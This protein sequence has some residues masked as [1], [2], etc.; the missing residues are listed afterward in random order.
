MKSIIL[1]SLL[2]TTTNC[3]ACGF[4]IRLEEF[5]DEEIGTIKG[6]IPDGIKEGIKENPNSSPKMGVVWIDKMSVY[7]GLTY[8]SYYRVIKSSED[9]QIIQ[10]YKIDY[11][12]Y[13][14]DKSSALESTGK[15]S[16]DKTT[17]EKA[18]INLSTGKTIQDTITEK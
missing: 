6:I 17:L 4:V 2:F 14:A 7:D 5:N 13:I 10:K 8:T 3:F 11:K 16:I 9:I 12:T 15:I 1:L 18:T